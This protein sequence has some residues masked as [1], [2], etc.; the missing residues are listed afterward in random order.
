MSYFLLPQ[1][2]RYNLKTDNFSST[3][4]C[5]F[6]QEEEN[7][8]IVINKTLY[9]YLSSIK[10]Q[11]EKCSI[12]WD[13]YKKYSNTYEYI[14]TIIPN[15]SQSICILKPLSRS[16]YKMIE[17]CNLMNIMPLLPSIC[18]SFHLA[19][20]PGGFIEA[21]VYLRNQSKDMYYGMTL[22]DNQDD[23][24]PGWK[25]SSNFLLKNKNVIIETGI[26]KKG[27]LMNPENLQGCY[28]K[29]KG[30]MN[31]ITGDGGFDFSVDFNNQEQNT[32]KLLFSQIA[33][34][35]AMQKE[36]G[37]F[38]IKFFDTFTKISIDLLYL[39]SILYDQ[40][41]FIKP[42]TSRQANSEKYIVCKGFLLNNVEDIV[43]R[44]FKIMQQFSSNNSLISLFNFELP[45]FFTKQVEEY[46]AIFGQCQIENIA[47]T[48]NLIN[49]N[50]TNIH[51]KLEIIKKNNIG[52]CIN[53]CQKYNLP[54]NKHINITNMF[55]TKKKS[56][57]TCGK[58]F[59]EREEKEV[60]SR[61]SSI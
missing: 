55:L 53:W 42:H 11:I 18:N 27:D 28:N 40:V 25:K 47:F 49:N 15:S 39:L 34:A 58:S 23:N 20:G 48:L 57:I 8:Q 10:M 56:A 30:T 9:K 14:N 60:I 61:K 16:F 7:H 33:F 36:K 19:E 31:L 43:N 6:L 21:F 17:I 3:I 52:K 29:Y 13:K 59:Q 24:V 26:D 1:I 35:I 2:K 22:L 45:Y 44:M 5:Q 46:N 12:E 32:S 51:D 50:T 41:Y 38:I 54:Y 37:I 4:S